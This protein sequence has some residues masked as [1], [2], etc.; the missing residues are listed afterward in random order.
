[1]AIS[2]QN[3]NAM[4]QKVTDYVDLAIE[5][6]NMVKETELAVRIAKYECEN[7]DAAL[8]SAKA[9]HEEARKEARSILIE[10]NSVKERYAKIFDLA[11]PRVRRW[12]LSSLKTPKPTNDPTS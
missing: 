6:D 10:I 7:A 1:M 8:A 5:F 2:L 9:K 12:H 11:G 4:S 3:L